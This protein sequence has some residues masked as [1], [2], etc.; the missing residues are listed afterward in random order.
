[1][2]P[3]CLFAVE[4]T[5]RFF[6]RGKSVEHKPLIVHP[7]LW[8]E[9]IKAKKNNAVSIRSSGIGPVSGIRMPEIFIVPDQRFP[10]NCESEHGAGTA[11]LR[12]SEKKQREQ[13]TYAPFPCPLDLQPANTAYIMKGTHWTVSL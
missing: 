5:D 11:R 7:S 8:R 6:R 13:Q 2:L 9:C 12:G 4:I 1:M 3:L 10:R